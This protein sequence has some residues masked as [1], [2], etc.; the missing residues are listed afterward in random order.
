M[1]LFN[2]TKGVYDSQYV[3]HNQIDS[4]GTSIC[5]AYFNDT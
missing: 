3:L 2:N 4:D 1:I 5:Q